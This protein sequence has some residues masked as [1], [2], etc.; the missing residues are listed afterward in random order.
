MGDGSTDVLCCDDDTVKMFIQFFWM[1][2]C[3]HKVRQHEIS[4]GAR[5]SIFVRL[6]P[7][8]YF[9]KPIPSVA[10]LERNG[11]TLPSKFGGEPTDWFFATTRE[12]L[13]WFSDVYAAPEF[14]SWFVQDGALE[15]GR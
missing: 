7:D 4:N 8:V 13:A 9:H 10:T 6:R 11:I 14:S 2:R 5:F 3:F 15:G 1:D 12:S